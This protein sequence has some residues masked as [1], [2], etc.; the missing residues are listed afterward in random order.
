[1]TWDLGLLI[2][3]PKIL[4]VLVD[5]RGTEDGEGVPAEGIPRAPPAVT[6]SIMDQLFTPHRGSEGKRWGWG[7]RQLA[8]S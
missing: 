1:M 4:L 7:P 8:E 5:S 6:Q 3:L 2:C